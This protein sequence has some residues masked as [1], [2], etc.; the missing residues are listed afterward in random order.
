MIAVPVLRL[1]SDSILPTYAHE[2]DAGADLYSYYDLSISPGSYAIAYTGVA[3]AIPAGHV[4]LVHPRS[5]LA[6]RLGVTVLNAPGTV[7]SG[8]RGE[9]MVNLINHGST[10]VRI[11]KGDRVAQIVFQAYE[12]AIFEEV[13]SFEATDRGAGGHGSTGGFSG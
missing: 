4:G 6:V 12:E 1:H 2:G 11:H 5:G 3:F 7:D 13:V 8:Y 10:T 9:V